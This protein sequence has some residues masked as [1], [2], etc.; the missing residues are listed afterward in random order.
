MTHTLPL[1][2]TF[3]FPCKQVGLD[4]VRGWLQHQDSGKDPGMWCNTAVLAPAPA[5]PAGVA[6]D[7]DQRLQCLRL[8]G[9]GRCPATAGRCPAQKGREMSCPLSPRYTL[10]PGSVSSRS[11]LGATRPHVSPSPVWQHVG[12]QVVALVNDTVGT[13]MSCGYD[14]PKCEIGLIVGKEHLF[15]QEVPYLLPTPLLY[16]AWPHASARTVMG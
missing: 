12:M 13:M 16:V 9:T 15:I 11:C 6:A 1:G 14:D 2:F 4:K 8:R 5:T 10:H 3:S 7:L